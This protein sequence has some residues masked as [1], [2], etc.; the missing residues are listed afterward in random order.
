MKKSFSTRTAVKQNVDSPEH[1]HKTFLDQL[2]DIYHGERKLNDAFPNLSITNRDELKQ[3]YHNYL[4]ETKKQVKR[5]ENVF[6][7][8][9]QKTQAVQDIP[10]VINEENPSQFEMASLKAVTGLVNMKLCHGLDGL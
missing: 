5:L 7:L 9:V 10:Q 1:L 6:E 4:Q 8:L 2:K 3:A